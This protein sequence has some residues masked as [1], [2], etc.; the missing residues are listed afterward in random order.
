LNARLNIPEYEVSVDTKTGRFLAGDIG[1]RI[2]VSKF[3]KGVTISAWYSFTNTSIFRDDFNRGYHDKGILIGI[4]LRLFTGKDSQTRYFYAFSPWT[5]D[6]G[7]DI[8]HYREIF[9]FMAGTQKFILTK[10][11]DDVLLELH[12]KLNFKRSL[13]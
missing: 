8:F 3:I 2:S 9:D 7:Q 6:V 1:T 13:L 4:P 10:I 11:K 12:T 5:R